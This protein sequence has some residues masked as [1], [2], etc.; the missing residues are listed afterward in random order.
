VDKIF[1]HLADLFRSFLTPSARENHDPDWQEAWQ[2]L[3]DYLKT[4]RRTE[5]PRFDERA[6]TGEQARRGWEP[7]AAEESLRQDYAN[8]ELPFASPLAEVKQSYK[9]LLRKYHP[10]RFASD[11]EKQRLATEI[12]QRINGSYRRIRQYAQKNSPS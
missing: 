3:D 11:A 7:S 8:L 5:G 9:R 12:T 4:G 1:D 2:E 10:D 6:R